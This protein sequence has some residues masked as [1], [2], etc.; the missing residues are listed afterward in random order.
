MTEFRQGD[1]IRAG[2]IYMPG[3]KYRFRTWEEA[4]MYQAQEEAP[5]TFPA[6][7]RGVPQRMPDGTMG[8]APTPTA[9]WNL[10][11]MPKGEKVQMCPGFEEGS[12]KEDRSR[13]VW[14][15]GGWRPSWGGAPEKPPEIDVYAQHVKPYS[16]PRRWLKP[17]EGD[18]V[19][20][21]ANEVNESRAGR[22]LVPIPPNKDWQHMTSEEKQKWKADW[23]AWKR[24]PLPKP[25]GAGEKEKLK[26]ENPRSYKIKKEVRQNRHNINMRLARYSAMTDDELI[27]SADPQERAEA[28]HNHWD[29]LAWMKKKH[30]KGK[31]RIKPRMPGHRHYVP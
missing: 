29:L 4:G 8:A 30:L 20:S 9:S 7:F 26:K 27:R 21:P 3:G 16:D 19:L 25:W 28:E 10:K 5:L 11:N 14:E 1:G 22:G 18:T 24:L 6:D 17:P 31:F 12:P 23:A 15:E 2:A 13:P